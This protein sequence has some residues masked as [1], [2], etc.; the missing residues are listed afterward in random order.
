MPKKKPVKCQITGTK[1]RVI[2][3]RLYCGRCGK[4]LKELPAQQSVV[5]PVCDCQKGRNE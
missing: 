5:A 3:N 2:G 1:Y 4:L